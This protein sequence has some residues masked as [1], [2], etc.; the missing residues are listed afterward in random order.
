MFVCGGFGR[1]LAEGGEYA[2][3]ALRGERDLV[4]AAVATARATPK[5]GRV[6]ILGCAHNAAWAFHA[7]DGNIDCFADENP[8]RVGTTFYGKP[9]LHPRELAADDTLVMPYGA[10]SDAIHKKFG[11]IYQVQ[12][13]AV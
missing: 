8:A 3:E 2:S 13:V 4:R 1:P 6:A 10:T 11:E 7:V 12:L 5:Q 9:V